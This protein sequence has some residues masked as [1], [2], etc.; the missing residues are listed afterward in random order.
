MAAHCH[1]FGF[2]LRYPEDKEDVTEIN[3]E[4]WH[5]RYVGIPAAAYIM[6]NGL[7]LEEFRDQLNA[8]IQEFLDWGGDPDVVA[9]FIQVSAEE[10]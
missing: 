7:C 10:E 3:Y 9:P 8:S 2:I 6:E 1:E 4:P 5:M